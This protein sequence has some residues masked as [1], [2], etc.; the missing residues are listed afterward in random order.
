MEVR[1]TD[2]E[3]A[4]RLKDQFLEAAAE[5]LK[6]LDLDH[7]VIYMGGSPAASSD[8]SLVS[9]VLDALSDWDG[10]QIV[11]RVPFEASDDAAAMMRAVQR[12]GGLA[13]YMKVGADMPSRQHTPTFDFDESV[14]KPTVA[15]LAEVILRTAGIDSG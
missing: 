6:E 5:I 4:E 13:T 14:L 12:R 2:T 3:V 1:A 10:L 9:H 11:D 7:R 8:D 15:Q